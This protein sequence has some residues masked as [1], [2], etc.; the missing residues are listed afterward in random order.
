MNLGRQND[1]G[2]FN[3]LL[4]PGHVCHSPRPVE[5]EASG[6]T[7]GDLGLLVDNPAEPTLTG[8]LFPPSIRMILAGCVRS[9][10]NSTSSPTPTV[11]SA[12]ETSAKFT[13]TLWKFA[14]RLVSGTAD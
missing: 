8:D 14:V 13:L 11:T 3:A 5:A 2:P 1:L 10:I 9:L 4:G 6:S 12:G 7:G